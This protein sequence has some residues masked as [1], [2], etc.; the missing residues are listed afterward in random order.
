[1]AHVNTVW[2]R[3]AWYAV[4]ETKQ[5]VGR[6]QNMQ[7]SRALPP[8]DSCVSLLI[9]KWLAPSPACIYTRHL[10]HCYNYCYWIEL[11]VLLVSLHSFSFFFLIHL[12]SQCSLCSERI[13]SARDSSCTCLQYCF[14]HPV[15]PRSSISLGSLR[16]S[17]SQ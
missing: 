3:H 5:K 17:R 13:S 10:S 11:L 14:R 12:S 2:I 15:R 4:R 1:M 6:L 16:L 9:K 7:A 8:T